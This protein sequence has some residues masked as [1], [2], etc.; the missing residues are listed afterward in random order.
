MS[1][2]ICSVCDQR[3]VYASYMSLTSPVAPECGCTEEKEAGE[4]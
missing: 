3:Y 1:N 2:D 4:E